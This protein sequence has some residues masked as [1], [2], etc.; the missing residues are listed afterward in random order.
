[1]K[2]C[3]LARAFVKIFFS[4]ARRVLITLLCQSRAPD[5]FKIYTKSKFFKSIYKITIIHTIYNNF[6]VKTDAS[7]QQLR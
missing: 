6:T 1:M 3:N 7:V 4:D 5:L 2:I